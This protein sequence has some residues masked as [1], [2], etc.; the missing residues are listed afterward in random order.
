MAIVLVG[1]LGKG[2][3]ATNVS[4]GKYTGYQTTAYKFP[5]ESDHQSQEYPASLFGTAL[6]K[7]LK[8]MGRKVDR[9]VVLGTAQAMWDALIEILPDEKQYE[10]LEHLEE[11]STILKAGTFTQKDLENWQEQLNHRLLEEKLFC[12]MVGAADSNDSQQA[13]WKAL[14]DVIANGDEI[15][16]DITNGFRHQPVLLMLMVMLLRWLR[17]LKQVD[18]YY[19]AFELKEGNNTCPVLKLPLCN[20]LLQSSEAVAT[21][22][23]TGNYLPLGET[24][25]LTQTMKLELQ[26]ISF[27]DETHQQAKRKAEGLRRRLGNQLFT[28]IQDD[29]NKLLDESIEWVAEKTLAERLA[30]KAHF[31]LDHR[32][33]FKAIALLWEA[34]LVATCQK[35]TLGDPME[36]K[37]RETAEQYLKE[38]LGTGDREALRQVKVLRNAVMHG[39]STQL[40]EVQLALH[41]PNEFILLFEKG[42]KLFEKIIGLQE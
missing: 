7:R 38:T 11:I 10:L 22:L 25:P 19:G 31:A 6:L 27:A 41:S 28:P 37:S 36:Y 3:Q 17:K 1:F 8:D 33:F 13:I 24:L 40:K 18:L 39:T 2:R 20:Q 23:H 35:H 29:L 30:W 15:V 34:I 21:L 32:Q 42:Y 12:R 4:E 14:S 9:W 26:E 5:M 16:V